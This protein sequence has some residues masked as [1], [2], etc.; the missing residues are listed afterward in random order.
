VTVDDVFAQVIG[1]ISDG[2]ATPQPVFE[3]NGE[4]RTL[5]IARLAQVG[6]QLGIEIEHP[7]V[8]TVSGLVLALLERPAEVADRVSYRGITL[9]VRDVEG[10]GAR[11]CALH[12]DPGVVRARASSTLPPAA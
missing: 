9:L 4:L 3:A 5:G 8:D 1:E 6:K 10:R 7:D 2:S 11:E 12:L